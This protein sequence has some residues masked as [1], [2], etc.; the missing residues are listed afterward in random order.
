MRFLIVFASFLCLTSPWSQCDI[1]SNETPTYEELIECLGSLSDQHEWL[2]L[3][4]MGPS[5]YGL[6]VYLCVVN[7]IGDSLQTFAKARSETTVLF[8]CATGLKYPMPEVNNKF[9]DQ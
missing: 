1:G 2:E 9:N 3:Y 5:D 8:N 7:G 4:A 6:P